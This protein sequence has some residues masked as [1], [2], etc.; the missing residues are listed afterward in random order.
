MF[1]TVDGYLVA[2]VT[3]WFDLWVDVTCAKQMCDVDVDDNNIKLKI[4][5]AVD[6]GVTTPEV[7]AEITSSWEQ[8]GRIIRPSLGSS[9]ITP[10]QTR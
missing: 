8:P 6:D 5:S 10:F 9:F 1:E 7:L 4:K 3:M 2:G